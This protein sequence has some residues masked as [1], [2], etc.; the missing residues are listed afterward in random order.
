[1]N[2]IDILMAT[3]N[4][5]LY[6]RNQ[7][8]SIIGQTYQDW[9]LIIHDDG[10]TD[11]TLDEIRRFAKIDTRIQIID[12]GVTGLGPGRNFWHLHNYVQAPFVCYCDQDDLWLPDNIAIKIEKITKLDNSKPQI[13][14]FNGWTWF[15]EDGNRIGSKVF[16]EQPST[17]FK[18]ALFINGGLQGASCVFNTKLL[19][20]ADRAHKCVYMH[21]Y[22][23]TLCAII[24]DAIHFEDIPLFLYRQHANNFSGH[25]LQSRRELFSPKKWSAPIP[26]IYIENYLSISDFYKLYE[27]DL[28]EEQKDCFREYLAFPKY[29]KLK[30]L[31][32]VLKNR[33]SYNGSQFK[34]FMKILLRKDYIA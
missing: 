18:D 25:V 27:S 30:R 2:H 3:Y 19:E 4:G 17:V 21:D 24:R 12:D 22:I 15:P 1:M 13:I 20:Y 32:S 7:I 9:K 28:T 14:C 8:L 34:L 23:L 16:R 31:T 26:V 33:F 11:N 29:S 10:S 5:G 6:I